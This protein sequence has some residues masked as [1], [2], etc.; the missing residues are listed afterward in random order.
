LASTRAAADGSARERDEAGKDTARAVLARCLS[1]A[2]ALLHPF[3]PFVTEEIWEKLTGRPGTLIVSPYPRG[4]E[5]L[6]DE[7]AERIVEA[8]R[9]LV[10]RVRNYRIERGFTP[11]QP[12][13]LAV[14]PA[15]PESGL[16]GELEPLAP[17]LKHLARLSDLTFA[18]PASEMTRDV[19]A[20]LSIGLSVGDRSVSVDAGK[21]SRALAVLDG[22]ITE[23]SAK[24][25]NSSF[26]DKAPL[27]VVEK[28]RRRL[29]E[30]EERRAALST[31][32]A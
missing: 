21:I 31:G 27:A 7:A 17:L 20:G 29:V 26:L 2:L 23:L 15:S 1:D 19:T 16:V 13:R 25:Q 22:E 6:H 32:G 30:L 3:M 4:D 5:T 10:T 12:V 24:L 9:A 14:D 11:T 28:T 8:M 18:P